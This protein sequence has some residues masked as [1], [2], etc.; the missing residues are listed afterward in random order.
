MKFRIRNE[1]A[2]KQNQFEKIVTPFDHD[3]FRDGRLV[4]FNTEK[5]LYEFLLEA[6]NTINYVDRSPWDWIDHWVSI[7]DKTHELEICIRAMSAD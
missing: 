6:R 1:F 5:D 2:K 7:N 4:E 3:K